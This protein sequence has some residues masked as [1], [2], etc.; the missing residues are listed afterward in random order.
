VDLFTLDVVIG[1]RAYGTIQGMDY[2]RGR[3]CDFVFRLRSPA[4]TV[5][6]AEGDKAELA[7]CFEGLGEGEIGEVTVYYK[8]GD[9]YRPVRICARRKSG[10]EERQGRERMEK[11]NWRKG[12]GDASESQ[13]AAGLGAVFE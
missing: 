10:E 11:T 3:G 5:Y 12:R 6:T 8:A 2:L 4:F 9:E 13:E 7:D 1:D